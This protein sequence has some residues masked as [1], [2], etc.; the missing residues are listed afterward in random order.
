MKNTSP[1]HVTEK[2]GELMIDRLSFDTLTG[3]LY[4]HRIVIRNG[5][6]KDKPFFVRLYNPQNCETG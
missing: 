2:S 5:V 4:N 6:R 1:A 3:R